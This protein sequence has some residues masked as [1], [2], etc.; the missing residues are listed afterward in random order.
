MDEITKTIVMEALKEIRE[1][2]KILNTPSV[3]E[4]VNG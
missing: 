2:A 3:E 4:S 1:I